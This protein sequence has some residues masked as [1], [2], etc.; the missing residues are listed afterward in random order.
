MTSSPLPSR[1]RGAPVAPYIAAALLAERR[2]I[3]MAFRGANATSPAQAR[4][5][6]AL[7]LKHDAPFDEMLRL[8]VIRQ[9]DAG[10]WFDDDAYDQ[11]IEHPR[12]RTLGVAA[13]VGLLA[14]LG[15]AAWGVFT[16][17]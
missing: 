17:G 13:V 3:A 2:R 12:F 5:L 9:G 16:A 14:L 7:S 10:Y 1:P 15:I 8:G 6:K 4:S 11:K